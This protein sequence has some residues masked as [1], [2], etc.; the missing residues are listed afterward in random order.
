MRRVLVSLIAVMA[1]VAGLSACGKD[2]LA[3]PLDSVKIIQT[4]GPQ[5]ELEFDLPLSVEKTTVR[6]IKEGEG[7]AITP[8][9]TITFNFVVVNGTDGKVLGTSYEGAPA[10]LKLSEDIMPGI[11]TG[12]KGQKVGTEVLVAIAPADIFGAEGF[13]GGVTDDDTLLFLA[14]ILSADLRRPLA[15]AKG[16]AVAAVPGLPTV[17]LSD[18]G[19]PT[20]ALGDG[21]AVPALVVQPLITG[22]GAKVEEGQSVTVHYTGALY[23]DGSVFQ[24]SWDRSEPFTFVVGSGEAIPGWDKALVGQTVGSQLLLVIPAVDAYGDAGQGKIPAGATL[25]FVVDILEAF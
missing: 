16:A 19:A 14:E 1:L 17:T 12:L 15:R 8:E 7:R 20:I 25:I 22:T 6:V 13:E 21:A 5:P 10:S 9:D 23:S 3:S 24:S 11:A 4:D 18:T 2:Q